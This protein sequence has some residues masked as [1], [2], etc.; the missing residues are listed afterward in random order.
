MMNFL[1]EWIDDSCTTLSIG[2]A[3]DNCFTAFRILKAVSTWLDFYVASRALDKVMIIDFQQI[4]PAYH[5]L[6]L[7]HLSTAKAGPLLVSTASLRRGAIRC[8]SRAGWIF[9]IDV[10]GQWLG[11]CFLLWTL[12]WIFDLKESISR[13][14]TAAFLRHFCFTTP[15]HCLPKC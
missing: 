13:P 14:E 1:S 11:M 15:A 5:T 10:L 9:I 12:D 4:Y 3:A 7:F 6:C 8:S 2:F